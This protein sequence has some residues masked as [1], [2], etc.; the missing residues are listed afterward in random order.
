MQTERWPVCLTLRQPD[1]IFKYSVFPPGDI[2]VLQYL[3]IKL[4]VKESLVHKT[5]LFPLDFSLY[6]TK[7]FL[8][9][10]MSNPQ[11]G[12]MDV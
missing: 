6:A 3:Y 2:S 4:I 9:S 8:K 11:S 1:E 5:L 12:Y 10:H 7:T